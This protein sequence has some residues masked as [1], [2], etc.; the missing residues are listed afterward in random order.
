MQKRTFLDSLACKSAT[1]K[2]LP[3]FG[4]KSSSATEYTLA[5]KREKVLKKLKE[6]QFLSEEDIIGCTLI[7]E[8]MSKEYLI[9]FIEG[10]F[11]KREEILEFFV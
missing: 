5:K 2:I 10:N 7:I 1:R 8:T 6:F 4:K 9:Q 11:T 3:F